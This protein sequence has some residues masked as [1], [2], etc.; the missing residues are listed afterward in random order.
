MTSTAKASR[1]LRVS[2]S[3][4]GA[5]P[6][7]GYGALRHGVCRKS[8]L[9]SII[10]L[11]GSSVSATS[12]RRMPT[13]RI[14]QHRC[15]RLGTEGFLLQEAQLCSRCDHSLWLVVPELVGQVLPLSRC[16]AAVNLHK[17]PLF[18][19]GFFNFRKIV[20]Q[21]QRIHCMFADHRNCPPATSFEV[22]NMSLPSLESMSFEHPYTL[23]STICAE[24]P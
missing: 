15:R 19:L 11:A 2:K 22:G 3:A 14:R 20:G 17:P 23:V 13:C 18:F 9:S 7:V 8:T 16:K 4:V 12:A 10:I 24:T 6:L 1:P 21:T 5:S